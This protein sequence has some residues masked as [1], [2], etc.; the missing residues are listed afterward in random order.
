MENGKCVN[1]DKAILKWFKTIRNGNLVV[2]CPVICRKASESACSIL[3]VSSLIDLKSVMASS[4]IERFVARVTLLT[5]D[6]SSTDMSDWKKLLENIL[7][8]FEPDQI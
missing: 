5:L 6:T 8:E 3:V 2:N 7:E 1:V 4:L